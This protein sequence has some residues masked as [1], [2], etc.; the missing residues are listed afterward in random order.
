MKNGGP[1]DDFIQE[2]EGQSSDDCL[3]AA[4][5]CALVQ[6]IYFAEGERNGST[7]RLSQGLDVYIKLSNK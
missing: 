4:F 2:R 5:S 7:V 1:G 3:A 6:H